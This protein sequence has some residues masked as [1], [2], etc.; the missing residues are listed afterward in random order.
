MKLVHKRL[1]IDIIEKLSE[2][3]LN[4]Q[5]DSTVEDENETKSN[6]TIARDDDMSDDVFEKCEEI[7]QDGEDK[8]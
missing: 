6:E 2:S 8:V 4:A 5:D 1:V 3:F 7:T